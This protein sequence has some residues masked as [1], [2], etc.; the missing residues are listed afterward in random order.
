MSQNADHLDVIFELIKEK[1]KDIKLISE[2]F[3]DK[4]E[5]SFG[6]LLT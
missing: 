2:Q 5:N 6:D 3:E 4:K 1:K